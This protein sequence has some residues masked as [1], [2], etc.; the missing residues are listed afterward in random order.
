VAISG[1]MGVPVVDIEGNIVI[2]FD[3]KKID[4]LLKIQ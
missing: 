4:E 1:Q 2:G 3:K